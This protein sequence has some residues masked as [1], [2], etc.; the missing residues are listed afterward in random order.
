MLTMPKKYNRWLAGLSMLCVLLLANCESKTETII[1]APE[2]MVYIP[3]GT[4]DMGGKTLQADQDEYPRHQVSVSDFFMDEAEVTNREFKAFVDATGY[5]TIAERDIDWDEM[6]KG[7][8]PETP[9][10]AD[11]LL[12]A[13]SLIFQATS[14]PVNLNYEG[15]WWRWTIG[16]NW[17]QPF[18]PGSS[19]DGKM[20]YPVVHVSYDDALAYAQWAGKRLPTEAEWEWAAM[21]GMED[22]VYPWGNVQVENA[23][24]KA[25]FWQGVFPYQNTEEDGYV[26][27]APVKSFPANG[28]G[29]YDMAGNVWE[30]CQ[31]KYHVQ[32][33]SQMSEVESLLNPQGP[34]TSYD[35]QEPYV[36]KFVMRGGSFLCSDSYCSGYR[37]S[38][39][40]KSTRDSAFG[41]T[42]FRCVKDVE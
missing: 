5:I 30:W 19:I 18:G 6:K 1:V 3:A 40:M 12:K 27:A 22:P 10:P 34:R 11:S 15:Q 29:L 2:G 17:R 8:P 13:G 7:L 31:D 14:G 24:D 32:A 4:F 36:E 9:K 16:A 21:G 35:P 26:D 37:V 28:Y 33:Y 25:N 23:A 42:G 41:H 38:R 39:R 20:D